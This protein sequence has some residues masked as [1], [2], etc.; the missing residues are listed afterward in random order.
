MEHNTKVDDEPYIAEGISANSNTKKKNSKK[1][2]MP[3]KKNKVS[4]KPTM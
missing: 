4:F 3:K 2:K 1:R